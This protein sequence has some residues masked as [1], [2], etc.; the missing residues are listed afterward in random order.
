MGV[1]RQI[2]NGDL[3]ADYDLSVAEIEDAVLY[4][5]VA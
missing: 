4:E 1:F 2:G 3:A 5:Q